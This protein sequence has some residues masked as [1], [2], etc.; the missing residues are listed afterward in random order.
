MAKWYV[1]GKGVCGRGAMAGNNAKPKRR[2][3]FDTKEEAELFLAERKATFEHDG[4]RFSANVE[5]GEA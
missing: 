5:E 3:P 1:V 2:G 4:R